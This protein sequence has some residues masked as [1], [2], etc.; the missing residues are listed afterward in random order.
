MLLSSPQFHASHHNLKCTLGLHAAA[1]LPCIHNSINLENWTQGLS[2]S[3][4]LIYISIPIFLNFKTR[5][6]WVAKAE[7][8]LATLLLLPPEDLGLQVC[9]RHCMSPQKWDMTSLLL[10][11]RGL[12]WSPV[13]YLPCLVHPFL[14]W[15]CSSKLHLYFW[16]YYCYNCWLHF[17]CPIKWSDHSSLWNKCWKK[18]LKFS[19]PIMKERIFIFCF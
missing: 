5:S 13:S 18:I 16:Y 11:G 15:V 1:R 6:L 10:H 8:R 3:L 12:P 17:P 4:P 14:I 2:G 19:T 9:M 7:L